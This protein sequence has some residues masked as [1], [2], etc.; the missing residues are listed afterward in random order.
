[1]SDEDTQIERL[2]NTFIHSLLA[3][4]EMRPRRK[5]RRK[6]S[7]SR[8]RRN[9]WWWWWWGGVEVG[10]LERSRIRRKNGRNKKVTRK[11]TKKNT[12]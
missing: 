5:R 1:M 2:S 4:E 12:I 7:R 11:E 10:G 6:R 8:R 9:R 3:D